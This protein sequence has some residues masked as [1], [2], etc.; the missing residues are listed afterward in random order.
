MK[1]I[2]FF[3][4]V[5]ALAAVSCVK[6]EGFTTQKAVLKASFEETKTV[7]AEGTKTHW[8][9]GDLLRTTQNKCFHLKSEIKSIH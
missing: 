4:A 7:L 1:K 8:T 2:L 3:A 6:E 9:P 5:A